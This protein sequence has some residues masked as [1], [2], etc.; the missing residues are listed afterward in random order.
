MKILTYNIH[1]CTQEKVDS[2]LRRKADIY[3][4]PELADP[5]TLRIPDGY[6]AYWHGD[7]AIKGLGV[8]VRPGLAS[9]V[10]S[11]F[12][13]ANKY[14]IPVICGGILVIASWPTRR[15]SN[16][17]KGYPQIA[18]EGLREYGSHYDVFPTVITG[19]LNLYKGQQD[20][21][22]EY[23]LEALAAYLKRYGM[24]SAYHHLTGERFGSERQAT[25]YHRFERTQPFF[26]DYTFTNI[27]VRE[28]QLFGWNPK[29][30]DH[31]AQ[32]TE[33]Q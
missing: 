16:A 24:V 3:V 9:R 10:P 32:V 31:V 11:W 12:N 19:D 14:F 17:P 23:S 18:L 5:A 28:Y 27:P 8:I 4:L 1:H 33:I 26:L 25:Y 13:P 2:V 20:E 21:T 7:I 22:E 15:E 6:T 29:F 30:S